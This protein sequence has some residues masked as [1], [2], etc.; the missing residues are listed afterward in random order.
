MIRNL[1]KFLHLE[2]EY[3]PECVAKRCFSEQAETFYKG[4]IGAYKKLF[5]KETNE[6]FNR[7]H[8]DLLHDYGYK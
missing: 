1:L 8:G 3:D 6:L 7:L 2:N 4:Q 5:S